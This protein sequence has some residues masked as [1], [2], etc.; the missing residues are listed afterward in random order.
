MDVFARIRLS[1]SAFWLP[2][3]RRRSGSG[4]PALSDKDYLYI[5][6]ETT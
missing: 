5:Q 6:K 4:S 1:A 3:F 2:S